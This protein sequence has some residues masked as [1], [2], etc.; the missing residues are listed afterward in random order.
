MKQNSDIIETKE[1][2]EWNF[3]WKQ[4]NNIVALLLMYWR[5]RSYNQEESAELSNIHAVSQSH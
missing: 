4:S 3:M 1:T 2:Q 5:K